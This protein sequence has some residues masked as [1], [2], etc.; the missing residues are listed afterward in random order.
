VIDLAVP[1]HGPDSRDV[2]RVQMDRAVVELD[3]PEHLVDTARADLGYIQRPPPSPR[4]TPTIPC[5][6]TANVTLGTAW[7]EEGGTADR[8][9]AQEEGIAWLEPTL[10]AAG[11]TPELE[12]LASANLAAALPSTSRASATT[13]NASTPCTKPRSGL[14]VSC[15]GPAT[16]S[17]SSAR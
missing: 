3:H 14:C 1:I 9:Q 10:A 15:T 5:T 17:D 6:H 4:W 8:C 13:A 7:L 12:I 2:L 11:I 16:R